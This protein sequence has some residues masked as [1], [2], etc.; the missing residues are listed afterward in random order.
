MSVRQLD[1]TQTTSLPNITPDEPYQ[2]PTVIFHDRVFGGSKVT[3]RYLFPIDEDEC[4][5]CDIWHHLILVANNDALD[6]DYA[7]PKGLSHKVLDLG[8]GTGIWGFHVVEQYPDACVVAVDFNGHQPYSIPRQVSFKRFDIED[9]SW[10]LS[11]DFSLAHLR[12]LYGSIATELWPQVYRNV[13]KHL[14]P[15]IG[16]I[17]HCEVDFTPRWEG[18]HIPNPSYYEQWSKKL[19]DCLDA[20]GRG[21]RIDSAR[22]KRHLEEAGFLDIKEYKVK[23]CVSPWPPD[24]RARELGR[25]A[26]IALSIG[27]EAMSLRPMCDPDRKDSMSYDAAKRLWKKAGSEICDLKYHAYLTIH[28]WRGRKPRRTELLPVQEHSHLAG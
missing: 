12:L 21:A 1:T 19:L 6:L 16:W 24:G 27:F 25:W 7:L 9:C 22:T 26:S 14:K 11:T 15:E 8:A 10:D 4:K 13:Y 3:S 2:L 20:R 17:E 18:A 23:C 5:R 28:T